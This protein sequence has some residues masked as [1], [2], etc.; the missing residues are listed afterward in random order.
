MRASSS[1]VNRLP[2]FSVQ[3]PAAP[4]CLAVAWAS[5][6]SKRLWAFV[7]CSTTRSGSVIDRK[8][9]AESVP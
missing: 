3:T 6:R 9:R 4:I 7:R 8:H 1:R 2:S 5:R